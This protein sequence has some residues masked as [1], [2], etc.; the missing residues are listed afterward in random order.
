MRIF[1]SIYVQRRFLNKHL[2]HSHHVSH[3]SFIPILV[4]KIYVPCIYHGWDIFGSTWIVVCFMCA[5]C[6]RRPTQICL[7]RQQTVITSSLSKWFFYKSKLEPEL[8][9][10][11]VQV[12]KF[13][14][15]YKLKTFNIWTR[16]LRRQTMETEVAWSMTGMSTLFG[17]DTVEG[18]KVSK[19]R[20]L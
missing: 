18:F 16:D 17:R 9:K 2:R 5:Q 19:H 7:G 3:V 8:W 10:F 1:C 6:T 13:C 20:R 15:P 4:S 11:K 14:F 12:W